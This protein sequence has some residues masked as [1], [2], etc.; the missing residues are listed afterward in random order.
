MRD[1]FQI[2]LYH[3][4]RF[5]D[6]VVLRN[7]MPSLDLLNGDI[8]SDKGGTPRHELELQTTVSTSAWSAAINA[9]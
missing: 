5:Q 7:G 6:D 1:S 8:I 3:T 2:A 9:A 4:W